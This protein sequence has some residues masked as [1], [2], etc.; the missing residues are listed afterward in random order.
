MPNGVSRT[1]AIAYITIAAA[2]IAIAVG[3]FHLEAGMLRAAL[4]AVGVVGFVV[5]LW[6]RFLWRVGPW[7]SP[8][9]HGTWLG[10]LRSDWIDPATSQSVPPIDVVFVFRQTAATTTVSMHTRESSSASVTAAIVRTGDQRREISWL[11]R[12]EPQSAY[13]DRSPMHYGGAHLEA[14]SRRHPTSL[15]GRYW[16]DRRTTGDIVLTTHHRKLADGFVD[17]NALFLATS[18]P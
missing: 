18:G 10:E 16:T 14:I 9:V 1:T 5:G 6:D 13:R 2:A 11:Y 15:T 17:G 4:G 3:G 8:I 12:N 7:G